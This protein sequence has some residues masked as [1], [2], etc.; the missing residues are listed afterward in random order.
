MIIY[1]HL[2]SI[3]FFA[4]CLMQQKTMP[5]VIE[6][7][8]PAE[9]R[10]I[11]QPD[12]N[13]AICRRSASLVVRSAFAALAERMQGEFRAGVTEDTFQEELKGYLTKFDTSPI[14]CE[15]ICSEIGLLLALIA[16]LSNE[17][18]V[19]LVFGHI[20]SDHCRLFHADHNQL[21]LVCTFFGK[22]TE[23][24]LNEDVNRAGLG[25]G[26]NDGQIPGS[27]V[28]RLDTYDIG[29][30]KGDLFPGNAGNGLVHRSPPLLPGDSGRLFL[31]IDASAGISARAVPSASRNRVAPVMTELQITRHLFPLKKRFWRSRDTKEGLFCQQVKA[32][33]EQSRQALAQQQQ[34]SLRASE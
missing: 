14:Q 12:V 1:Y 4:G 29:I 31:A 24:L 27:P 34:A 2:Q 10:A 30:M 26:T 21:R 28:Q 7:A 25:K 33:Y 32:R 16:S 13:M 6:V 18:R 22:G 5:Q 15:I 23:F 17:R 9:L 20:Q 8:R 11:L 19:Q 3:L